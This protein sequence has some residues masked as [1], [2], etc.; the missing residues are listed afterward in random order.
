MQ[1]ALRMAGAAAWPPNRWSHAKPPAP[2][3]A[4]RLRGGGGLAAPRADRRRGRRAVRGRHL[5]PPRRAAVLLPAAD[6]RLHRPARE[7]ARPFAHAP[8]RARRAVDVR[9]AGA[10]T[11]RVAGSL[12]RATAA[13]APRWR[14]GSSSRACSRSRPTSSCR[15]SGWPAPTTSSR[16]ALYDGRTETVVVAPLLGLAVGTPELALGDGLALVH[17]EALGRRRA[18][19][20]AVGAGRRARPPARRA[21]LGGRPGRRLARRSRARAPAPAAHRAAPV[22]GGRLRL[23]AAGLDADRRRHVAAVR[24]RGARSPQ[25]RSAARHGR[26]GGRA[27][28]V[29]LADRAPDA[30]RRRGRLGPAALRDGLRPARPRRGAQR[31]PARPARAARAQGAGV[32]PSPRPPGRAVRDGRRARRPRRARGPHG[33][34]SSARSSPGSRATRPSTRSWPS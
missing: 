12:R 26:P 8:A 27:A 21:A 9:P 11:C 4:R 16:W 5:R 28:R 3:R 7:P 10:T 15:P 30:A 31:P 2:R 34:R 20:G 14:C 1:A 17:G 23:R 6:R 33:G 18:V 13:S 24:A 25:R 22:R 19:R 32:R 29:L